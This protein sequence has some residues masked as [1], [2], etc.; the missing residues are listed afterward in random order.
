MQEVLVGKMARP[1][2]SG[3][4][5][6]RRGRDDVAVDGACGFGFDGLSSFA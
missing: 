4:G 3:G 2:T 5:G 1:T 6:G